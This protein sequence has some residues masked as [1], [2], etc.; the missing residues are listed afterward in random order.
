MRRDKL[1]PGS[2]ATEPEKPQSPCTIGDLG[3]IDK[4]FRKKTPPNYCN[5]YFCCYTDKVLTP[6]RRDAARAHANGAV[7]FVWLV[8][9]LS[10]GKTGEVNDEETAPVEEPLLDFGEAAGVLCSYCTG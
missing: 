10:D 8:C 2:L 4:I 7:S 1:R 9:S 5:D 6:L 3:G